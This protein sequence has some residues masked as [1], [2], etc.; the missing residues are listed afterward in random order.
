M[1]KIEFY[2]NIYIKYNINL[3]LIFLV[4]LFLL[5]LFPFSLNTFQ[6]GVSS[7]YSFVF[8]PLLYILIKRCIVIPKLNILL[9]FSFYC[10]LFIFFLTFNLNENNLFIRRTLSFLVFISIFSLS[11]I[12]IKKNYYDAFFFTLIVFASCLC[13]YSIFSYLSLGGSDL[14]WRAKAIVG[15]SR[16]GFLYTFVIFFI[17]FNKYNIISKISFITLLTIGCFLTY[18]RSSFLALFL[19]ISFLILSYFLMIYNN[20]TRVQKMKIFSILFLGF[21]ALN[22]FF[23]FFFHNAYNYYIVRGVLL[24]FDLH[25]EDDGFDIFN[26]KSSEGYRLMILNIILDY[27]NYK[28]ILGTGFLGIWFVNFPEYVNQVDGSSIFIGSAHSQYFDVMLRTGYV[29]FVLFVYILI[30]LLLYFYK[31]NTGIFWGLISIIIYSFFH[32]TFKLSYGAFI[33]S[34][35]ISIYSNNYFLNEEAKNTN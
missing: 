27:L 7:N 26:Y 10:C 24:L 4:L 14:G 2:K 29:G 6:G 19:T 33:I 31:F 28:N 3:N 34:F 35:L 12:K 25:G 18:S 32:E 23:Y 17:F 20:T 30:K 15:T 13:T 22:L 1:D 21:I 8:F 9:I 16:Y 11:F 5:F